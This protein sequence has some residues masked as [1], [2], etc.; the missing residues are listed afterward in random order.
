MFQEVPEGTASDPECSRCIEIE[1]GREYMMLTKK[2]LVAGLAAFCLFSANFAGT[3]WAAQPESVQ[4]TN[5][6]Q[7][8]AKKDYQGYVWRIDT[9]NLKQLPRNFRTAQSAY[10]APAAKYHLDAA[11]VP[12]RSGLDQLNI[13]GS[14][15]FSVGEF[16]ALADT[17][18][19]Q[20]KGPI[21]VVDL[22]QESH[23]I[24]NG[25]AVSWYGKRNW[26]NLGRT[27]AEV[28]ADEMMRIKAAQGTTVTVAELNQQKEAKNP[29]MEKVTQ[30]FT[31]QE[32]VES[33]GFHYVRITA[34]DHVWPS[35]QNIDAFL[36]FYK[37]LPQNA[38]LHFH[39][40]AGKG[41]TTS[42]MAMYD[43][44]RNPSLA[45]KDI[46]YRQEEIG[47][48]YLGYTGDNIKDN[49]KT[50]AFQYKAKMIQEF[51][52]YVQENHATGYAVTWSEW[53]KNKKLPAVQD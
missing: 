30:V 31:E 39:C 35:A 29:H 47:G 36:A 23:G 42:F 10:R 9:P 26:A 53:L 6:V 27:A 22:R 46:L 32:L 19:K 2:R 8:Q 51:Y 4:T 1:M 40:Q 50:R 12:T 21:Y 3:V 25:H 37:T 28:R 17:L 5:V 45:L 20:A 43:M 24:F 38:W 16:E 34:T 33:A 14:A 44:L 52:N 11:Y 49:W 48:E 41:R 18:R 7:K 13:S 15:E